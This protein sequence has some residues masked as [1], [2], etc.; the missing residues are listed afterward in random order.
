MKIYIMTDMEGV[1][2]VVNYEDWCDSTGR[3]YEEGKKLL[4]MEVNAAIEGFMEAGATEI[5]VS[6]C[7]GRGGI[8]NVLL[9]NRV[10]YR[11]YN[12]PASFPVPGVFPLSLDETFDAI[13]WVGQHA[14]AGTEYAHIAHTQDWKFIDYRVNGISIGEFGE[15]A[16]VAASLGVTAI[17]GSGDEA[18]AKEAEVLVKGIETVSVKKGIIPGSGD[19]YNVEGYSKI[20]NGAIHVHPDVARQR[21]RAGAKKALQRFAE[22]R[23]QFVMPALAPP[24]RLDVQCRSNGVRPAY[25]ETFAH[26][27]SI[28]AL[29][30]SRRN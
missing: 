29:L 14:K 15:M 22:D 8:N 28:I 16:L 13:A 11:R 9:D 20:N 1:A 27:D 23:T 26:P 10:L 6:D 17:F 18:F 24:F 30:N 2:G 3:Y 12:P 21:I 25:S 4:T 5:L 19:L 7:H